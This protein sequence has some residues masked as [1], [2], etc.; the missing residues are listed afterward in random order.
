MVQKIHC[1]E[2]KDGFTADNCFHCRFFQMTKSEHVSV[3]CRK[4]NTQPYKTNFE[5]IYWTNALGIPDEAEIVE[6]GGKP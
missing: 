1:P 6:E 4:N 3:S 2:Q 5:A